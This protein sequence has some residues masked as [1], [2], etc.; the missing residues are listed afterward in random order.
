MHIDTKE[1]ALAR[2]EKAVEFFN[3][4]LQREA[5]MEASSAVRTYLKGTLGINELTSDEILKSIKGSKDERYM[6]DVRH[7]FMYCDLVKF[8]KYEPNSEDFNKVVE[9]AKRIIV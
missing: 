5:Y 3:S 2:L 9:H 4:G 8:A 6:E 7:C 1:E